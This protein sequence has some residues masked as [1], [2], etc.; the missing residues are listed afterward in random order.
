MHVVSHLVDDAQAKDH[1]FFIYLAMH[2]SHEKIEVTQKCLDPYMDKLNKLTDCMTKFNQDV[3]LSR[4]SACSKRVGTQ[5]LATCT[6][7]A[8]KSMINHLKSYDGVWENTLLIGLSDNGA[9]LSSGD[10]YPL[11]GGKGYLFEGGVRTPAFVAGGYLNDNR[12]GLKFQSSTVIHVTDWYPTI[13]SAIGLSDDQIFNKKRERSLDGK[14]MWNAIQYG[15]KDIAA[16]VERDFLYNVDSYECSSDKVCGAYR[17]GKYK[18]IAA[19]NVNADNAFWTSKYALRARDTAQFMDYLGCGE[20][21]PEVQTTALFGEQ[22][23]LSLPCS[24]QPCM[25][26]I[27]ADP[28][29]YFDL[30][31]YSD[32]N[33]L[34]QYMNN[35]LLAYDDIATRPLIEYYADSFDTESDPSLEKN[36]GQWTSWMRNYAQN[37]EIIDFEFEQILMVNDYNDKMRAR[38]GIEYEDKDVKQS[39][40]YKLAMKHLQKYKSQMS[41]ANDESEENKSIVFSQ[42]SKEFLNTLKW[43]SI[44]VSAMILVGGLLL[45]VKWYLYCMYGVN[46]SRVRNRNKKMEAGTEIQPLLHTVNKRNK[47]VHILPKYVI[48]QV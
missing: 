38:N 16:D 18:L 39:K 41:A 47:T 15:T 6:D 4:I 5:A 10:N 8:L 25:F 46:E 30:S 37:G 7:E 19:S 24:N 13:L 35:M 27:A 21:P 34:Y 40:Y 36:N 22:K 2:G 48:H 3:L 28:C 12:K 44:T 32:Y 26:D 31:G 33:H 9:E 43:M 17:Y 29:E 14:N 1:P 11:R 23:Y 42:H 45:C 20:V